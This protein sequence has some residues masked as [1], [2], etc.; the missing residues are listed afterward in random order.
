MS[1]IVITTFGSLGDLHPY[2]AIA[3]ELNRRGHEVIIATAQCYRDYVMSRGL[4]FRPVRRDCEWLN[5]P[6]RVRRY[7]HLRL[8]LVR[9]AREYA[10]P[11]LRETYDDLLAA[12]EGADLLVSQVPLAARLVAEK[13]GIPWASTIHIPL[14]FFSAYDVPLL[15]LAPLVFKRLRWLGPL[16]WRPTFYISK[17]ATR[18]LARPWY[19]LHR[20]L[21]LPLA[22]GINCLGDSHS[23]SLVLALFSNLLADK[24]PDWPAHTMITGFPFYDGGD[25]NALPPDLTEFLDAGPAPIVFTL[26]TAVASDAGTFFEQSA[27]AAKFIGQRAV[28]VLKDPRNRPAVLPDGVIAVNYAPFT[29][30]FPRA[31]AIVHHG[32][33]GT[34]GLAMGAGRPMLVVPHAWDQPDNADRVIRLGVARMLWPKRYTAQRA[35]HSLRELLEEPNYAASAANAAERM[36]AEQGTTTACDALETMGTCVP[37]SPF[38]PRK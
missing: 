5:D 28:L 37:M 23:P 9:L 27:A 16:F 15:P 30:L 38:A 11:Q 32:G 35:A 17:R 8:G 6:E 14:L 33:I 29:Q 10:L 22:T 1:R 20:E 34:T 7:A 26:G 2:L 19:Q 25:G 3:L 18:F 31:A 12:V 24:Q 36:A 21:G 4:G 13:T